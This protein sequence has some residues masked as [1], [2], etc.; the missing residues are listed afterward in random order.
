MYQRIG[1][2]LERL[3][4]AFLRFR[5]LHAE[6]ITTTVHSS[7]FDQLLAPQGTVTMERAVQIFAIINLTIIGVSHVLRPRVWVD[8]LIFCRERGEAG[9]FAIALLN[10][11][12]GS[13]VVAFHNVWAGLPVV[14][15]V[16]GWANVF[17]AL[18]YFTFPSFGLKRL[19][20]LSHERSNLVVGGGICFLLLASILGVHV[21]PEIVLGVKTK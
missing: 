7:T 20:G 15:T 9:V 5:K 4:V 17:K 1:P 21:F 11:I 2:R 12:F 18:L 6:T 16:L 14:L 13:I 19:Q 10:L 8:F 3:Q